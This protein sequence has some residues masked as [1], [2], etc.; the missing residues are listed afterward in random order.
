MKH[1]IFFCQAEIEE[2][3]R[4]SGR[5]LGH[6]LSGLSNKDPKT[7][8][9]ST[10]MQELSLR[11][12]LSKYGGEVDPVFVQSGK[13]IKV[14]MGLDNLVQPVSRNQQIGADTDD[15]A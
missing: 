4:F 10:I 13:Y 3:K 15:G 1:G 14:K 5:D 6:C 9:V 7:P 11:L 12:A 2:E 8:E